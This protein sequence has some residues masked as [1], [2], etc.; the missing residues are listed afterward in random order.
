MLS[1]SMHS[2][3]PPMRLFIVAIDVRSCRSPVCL[4]CFTL[5]EGL[6]DSDVCAYHNGQIGS[7]SHTSQ[8]NPSPSDH[9][10]PL[11]AEELSDIRTHTGPSIAYIC[12]QASSR[13]GSIAEVTIASQSTTRRDQQLPG[14]ARKNDLHTHI[15]PSASLSLPALELRCC[16]IDRSVSRAF[17]LRSMPSFSLSLTESPAAYTHSSMSRSICLVSPPAVE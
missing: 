15:H 10:A 16:P 13:W 11:H 9:P 14:K 1:A 12:T 6:G 7:L 2:V 5:T 4:L 8:F 3:R 17:P